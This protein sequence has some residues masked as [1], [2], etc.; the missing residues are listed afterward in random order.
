MEDEKKIDDHNNPKDNFS[1]QAK[2]Y[3]QYRPSYPIAFYDFIFNNVKQTELAWDC[4]TGNGQ[5][6]HV[7]AA[8]F[9]QVYA[10][11]ISE[12]QLANALK[13]D[14][15]TYA[16]GQA[17]Q[18][19]FE[20]HSFDLI[21]VAQA[22]HW[23][24]FDKFFAEVKRTLKP[25][26]LFVA[27]GYGL[28]QISPALNEVIMQL[29]ESILGQYWDTERKH[30]EAN[31]ATIHFPFELIET[32]QLE[33]T[34]TWNFEQLIGYLNTWSALQHYV[35]ANG[36]NPIKLV[37]EALK[38]AWGNDVDREIHFPLIIKAGRV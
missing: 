12:K 7:L 35:S 15:I 29:Y 38:S 36:Q 34:T 5:V 24:N 30:I 4:A 9:T 2:Q 28:M 31:Y 3:A 22:I 37:F 27:V 19:D 1:A 6:A 23:F 11:D 33:I 26:G 20:S 13:R 10:T 18:T 32:P 8:T 17:E 16:I 14:N 21:T 25:G